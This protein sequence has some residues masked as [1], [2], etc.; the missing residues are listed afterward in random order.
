MIRVHVQCN[1]VYC[2]H[3]IMKVTL[4]NAARFKSPKHVFQ[5]VLARHLYITATASVTAINS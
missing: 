2:G 1:S 4:Y 3:P 5:P